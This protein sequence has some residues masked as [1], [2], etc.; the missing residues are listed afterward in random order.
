MLY[1]SKR[2][3]VEFRKPQNLSLTY[4]TVVQQILIRWQIIIFYTHLSG[5]AGLEYAIRDKA[6]KCSLFC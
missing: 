5:A 6:I 4:P 3:E 1:Q 2:T